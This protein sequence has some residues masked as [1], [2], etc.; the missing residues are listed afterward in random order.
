MLAADRRSYLHWWTQANASGQFLRKESPR[1]L[2]DAQTKLKWGHQASFV[3]LPKRS[4]SSWQRLI[5]THSDMTLKQPWE[6]REGFHLL[7]WFLCLELSRLYHSSSH[8]CI[9]VSSDWQKDLFVQSSNKSIN[10]QQVPCEAVITSSA[11]TESPRARSPRACLVLRV[12]P[13][14]IMA[15]I[16]RLIPTCDPHPDQMTTVS[17]PAN[18]MHGV[19]LE[20]VTPPKTADMLLVQTQA[21]APRWIVFGHSHKP[22]APPSGNPQ[23]QSD[24][25]LPAN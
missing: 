2:L 12:M 8:L 22:P 7:F 21:R 23:I 19:R 15:F 10:E 13:R 11:C 25:S 16:G 17:F 4:T 24:L 5:V 1:F 6:N 18:A 20:V 3:V 14:T 9:V